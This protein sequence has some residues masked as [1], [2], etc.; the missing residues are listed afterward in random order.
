M[1][2]PAKLDPENGVQLAIEELRRQLNE[3]AMDPATDGGGGGAVDSVFGRTGDVT[4]QSGDYDTSEVPES[5]N[6]YFTDERAQDAVGGALVDSSTIDFTYDDGTGTITAAVIPGGVDH[7]SLAGLGDDDHTQYH[8]DARG[9]ARYAR[10][11]NNLSDLASAATARD[12]LGLEIGADVQAYDPELAALA[13]LT[14]AANKLPRFTG[15]GT[16]DLLDF[17]DEDDMASDS[18]TAVPSQ[19]STK[20]YV[21]A[22]IGA[23]SG[24]AVA[25]KRVYTADGTWTKP[26]GLAFI[27]VVVVGDGAGG[28]GAPATGAN[29][30]GGAGGG[31]GGV[32][33]MIIPAADLA[34]TEDVLVG[35]GGAGGVTPVF[36]GDDGEGSSFGDIANVGTS[37]VWATGGGGGLHMTAG[38][39]NAT[40]DGGSAGE[41]VYGDELFFG[42]GGLGENR[43]DVSALML[44]QNRGGAVPG[45]APMTQMASFNNTGLDGLEYG[46]GGGGAVN[47][48][49]QGNRAGGAGAGGVVIVYEYYEAA[50][51]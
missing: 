40:A 45:F 27:E 36:T 14:S 11:S 6:L 28:A 8:N 44:R 26:T 51:A 50:S 23:G 20:A 19:Q 32:A 17:K 7:G 16:A 3:L 34:A 47:G 15:S 35:S 43:V 46:G 41:G 2:N 12:N 10:R 37:F 9:D 31:G 25:A 39:T 42:G 30:S 21:D 1:I 22:L 33:R 48:T 13:G 29:R 49:S 18:N 24:Y 5:G 4:A 38:T